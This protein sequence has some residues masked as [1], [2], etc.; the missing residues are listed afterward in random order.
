[1]KGILPLHVFIRIIDY[2]EEARDS[3]AGIGTLHLLVLSLITSW[4]GLVRGSGK[5]REK[6]RERE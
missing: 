4:R 3:N 6:R 5:A 1:L 2:V